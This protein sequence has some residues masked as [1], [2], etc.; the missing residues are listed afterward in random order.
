MAQGCLQNPLQVSSAAKDVSRVLVQDVFRS[1]SGGVK[2]S[3]SSRIAQSPCSPHTVH[4]QCIVSEDVSAVLQ[5][6]IEWDVGSSACAVNVLQYL[7]QLVPPGQDTLPPYTERELCD[8]ELEDRTLSRV[9]TYVERRRSPSR[10]ERFNESVSGMSYFRYWERLTVINC[11][12][13]RISKDLKT[14]AKCF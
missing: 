8:K 1:S 14:R 5:S 3:P 11:T 2:P 13:Y 4:T 12:L 10:R 7:L 6:H 9:L